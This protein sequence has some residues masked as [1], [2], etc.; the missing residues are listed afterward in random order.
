MAQVTTVGL[1]TSKQVFH[2]HGVDARG[3]DVLTKRL[4]RAKVLP[5]MSQL[6]PCLIGMEA[7]GGTHYWA[8][9]FCKLGNTVTFRNIYRDFSI[10]CRVTMIRPLQ[11]PDF[12]DAS[13]QRV[14][15]RISGRYAVKVLPPQRV[16]NTPLA[17]RR[18][19]ACCQ[20]RVTS[21]PPAVLWLPGDQR[22]QTPR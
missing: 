1:D 13:F 18:G 14:F 11:S 9:E 5:F 8:R 19:R 10:I 12:S 3:H 2:I 16:M 22:C 17:F 21:T 20:C 4:S 7:S 6:P 15:R